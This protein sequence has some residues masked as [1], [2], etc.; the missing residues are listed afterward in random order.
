MLNYEQPDCQT[1]PSLLGPNVGTKRRV[2]E[3]CERISP[4]YSQSLQQFTSRGIPELEEISWTA[5]SGF[6]FHYLFSHVLSLKPISISEKKMHA[7]IRTSICNAF[8]QSYYLH[9]YQIKSNF[10]LACFLEGSYEALRVFNLTLS[11]FRN[12]FFF[13]SLKHGN[14]SLCA[15]GLVPLNYISQKTPLP[16]SQPFRSAVGH[17]SVMKGKFS[18]VIHLITHFIRCVRFGCY[19]PHVII[20]AKETRMTWGPSLPFVETCLSPA[21]N[22]SD[23]FP[24][25][26]L[27]TR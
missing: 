22:L 15:W 10:S 23:L 26:I 24:W 11:G 9:L 16:A 21:L 27:D 3:Q 20:T 4:A 18:G 12:S 5:L 6:F 14:C 19:P 8:Y 17:G 7:F 13:P 25:S 1:G 2:P